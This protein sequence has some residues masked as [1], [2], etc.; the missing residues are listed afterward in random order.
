M[1]IRDSIKGSRCER[2][3]RGQPRGGRPCQSLQRRWRGIRP[4]RA[5]RAG[6]GARSAAPPRTADS[7]ASDQGGASR[8]RPGRG[9]C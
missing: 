5:R 2:A 4:V 3:L 7:V 9:D 6:A 1:C 8:S